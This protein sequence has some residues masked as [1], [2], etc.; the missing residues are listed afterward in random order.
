MF[1]VINLKNE[2]QKQR[3]KWIS[4]ENV[5]EYYKTL[6]NNIDAE[7]ATTLNQL[8]SKSTVADNTFDFDKLDTNAIFHITDIRKICIDYRLRF[9]DTVYFKDNYPSEAISKI[10]ALEKTHCTTLGGFKIVAPM[11]VFK[12]KKADDPL[13]FVPMGNGFY[14]LIHKW[15]N[16]ISPFRK[17]K[18]WSIKN[19]ENL[20]IS[21]AI[22]SIIFTAISYPFFFTK[23]ASFG[24]LLMLFMFYFKGAVGMVF[25]FCGSSGK[26]FSEYSWQSQYDKIS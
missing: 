11:E 12:L 25:I 21:L 4:E 20:A 26:N 19:I 6:F 1:D 3:S 10:Q 18:Y 22:I 14:Y 7:N 8:N 17:L 2:L 23:P 24:Y 16:D 5:L 15:G 13:L 9:L